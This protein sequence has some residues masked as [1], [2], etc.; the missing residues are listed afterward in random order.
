MEET[1]ELIV[2][3]L[4]KLNPTFFEMFGNSGIYKLPNNKILEFSTY[5]LRNGNWKL[6]I[7]CMNQLGWIFYVNYYI[8]TKKYAVWKKSGIET[9]NEEI[10]NIL[11]D[12]LL[13]NA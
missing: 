9:S 2:E 10:L 8:N 4:K 1:L 7:R 5:I 3:L 11:N 13:I 12:F 6:K